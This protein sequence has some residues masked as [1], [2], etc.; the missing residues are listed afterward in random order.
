MSHDVRLESMSHGAQDVIGSMGFNKTDFGWSGQSI[1]EVVYQA[2][3]AASVCW[4]DT[5]HGVFEDGKARNV[6]EQLLS[7]IREEIG[8]EDLEC[9]T[10]A[11]QPKEWIERQQEERRAWAIGEA[12]RVVREWPDGGET[13]I[14]LAEKIEAF[15]K[16]GTDEESDLNDVAATDTFYMVA[17]EMFFDGVEMTEEQNEILIALV[18]KLAKHGVRLKDG[19]WA[20]EDER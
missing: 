19:A 13:L 8:S 2:V 17:A 3:G 16:K 20:E 7:R 1:E 18:D 10:L 5:P 4:S 14:P 11:E 15:V 9:N 12:V 6:A